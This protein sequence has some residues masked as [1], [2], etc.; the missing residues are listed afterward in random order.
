[1][2][3]S[4][5]KGLLDA[6]LRLEAIL[7]G[8]GISVSENLAQ[9]NG[10]TVNTGTGASSTGTQRVAVAYGPQ[11]LGKAED[12]AHV[13]GDVGVMALGVANE[14]Q[15]SFAADGDYV[16]Q[17][18]DR[19]GNVYVT[20]QDIDNATQTNTKVVNTGGKA[21]DC[22]T[23]APA[24]TAADMVAQ[25]YDITNGGLLVNQGNLSAAQDEVACYEKP[26]ATTT[27]CPTIDVS[28]ALE[29]SS[30]SKA[31]AGVFYGLSGYNSLASAQWILVYNSATV[32][33][34]GA[35]TPIAVIRAAAS[36]NFS[37]DTGKFGI[38]CS[39]GISWSNST[40]ATIFNKTLG[41]ADCYVSLAFK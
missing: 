18:T 22:T 21:V 7:N 35:V 25:A 4:Q 10:F 3:S 41:A 16:P 39:A 38:F 40:D 24:Y 6:I 26:D 32:P 15:V 34:N 30:V 1:M 11:D 20:G 27:Y 37:F 13:T 14:A 31:S 28:G 36:A 23:Y 9:V 2:E 17:A 8:T 29:A 19:K 5:Y 12:V 33:A